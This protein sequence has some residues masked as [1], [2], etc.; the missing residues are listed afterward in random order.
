MENSYGVC[1]LLARVAGTIF[2]TFSIAAAEQV[3]V[4]PL[5]SAS[6]DAMP[7]HVVKNQ[8]FSS[9][10][11]KGLIGTLAVSPSMQTYTT[12]TYGMTFNFLPVGTFTMGSPADE[13]G[14]ENDEI[15][16]QVTLTGSFYMQTTEVTQQQW[17][18]VVLDAVAAGYLADGVLDEQPST[19]AG[20]VY[21]PE[22]PVE[23]VTWNNVNTWI[24]ALNQ[25]T[26][27]SY[28]LPTEAQWEYAARATTTTAWAYSYNYDDS[29][30]GKA[31]EDDFNPNLAA[32]GWYVWQTGTSST[33]GYGTET[34]PVAKKQSNGWG[35]YDMHGNVAEWCQDWYGA[36]PSRSVTDPQ[37]AA[38]S[39][40]ERVYRGGH[41]NDDAGFT[42]SAARFSSDPDAST[43]F[44]GFRLTLYPG[45]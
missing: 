6:G 18:E 17:K 10:K 42:R 29:A 22:Y 9:E 23:T 1:R 39:I 26:G 2:I 13:P 27:R 15:Q 45:E 16:H 25:L 3:V 20:A 8:T 4:I 7:S 11:G 43:A 34:K 5:L 36:Y 38:S 21:N 44:L 30:A 19:S 14:R 40:G 35:L 28:A 33:V 41:Y 24:T 12:P 31:I 32:M 37:G